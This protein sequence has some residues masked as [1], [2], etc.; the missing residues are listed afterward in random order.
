LASLPRGWRINSPLDP[1]SDKSSII[2]IR[3]NM[4]AKMPYAS[5]V[6]SLVRTKLPTSLIIEID[7]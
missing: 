1:T 6:S 2:V 3:E 4:I 5:G 7:P